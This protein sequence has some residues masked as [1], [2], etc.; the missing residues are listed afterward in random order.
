[1]LIAVKKN[2]IVRLEEPTPHETLIIMKASANPATSGEVVAVG[3]EVSDVKVGD[4]VSFSQHAGFKYDV[5]EISYRT[6]PEDQV[7]AVLERK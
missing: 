5:H 6:M 1:M 4:M 7:M 2:V 3:S